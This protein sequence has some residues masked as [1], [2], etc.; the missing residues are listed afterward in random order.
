M[1][2]TVAAW[3]I[4]VVPGSVFFLAVQFM[5]VTVAAWSL[6]VVFGS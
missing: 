1:A 4:T 2:V 3:S 5:A 6:I